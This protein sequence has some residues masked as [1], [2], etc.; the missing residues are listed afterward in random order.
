MSKFTLWRW[1]ANPWP[2]PDNERL[3]GGVPMKTRTFTSVVADV[4]C[5]LVLAAV[6]AGSAQA[7]QAGV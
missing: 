6:A 7:Q 2:H 3:H 4:T 1:I 5:I